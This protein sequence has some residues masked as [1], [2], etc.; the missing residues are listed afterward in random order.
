RC[1]QSPSIISNKGI[2]FF[3]HGSKSMRG[4]ECLLNTCKG[5]GG[6][7]LDSAAEDG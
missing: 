2:I 5:D 3:L 6:V 7:G 4:L 1:N